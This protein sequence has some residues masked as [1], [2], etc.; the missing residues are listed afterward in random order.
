LEAFVSQ[1][2]E[3]AKDVRILFVTPFYAP[4]W[5]FG[6]PP[7]KI[8]ALARE[9]I[10][11]GHDV[12]IV[13]FQ[14][15][16]PH[17]RSLVTIDSVRVQYLPWVGS[18]RYP[19]PTSWHALRDEVQSAS[20]VHCFGLYNLICPVAAYYTAKFRKPLLVEPMGMFVPRVRRFFLKQIYNLLVTRWLFRKASAVIATSALE[21][22]ELRGSAAE[23][24]IVVRHNGVALE[25]VPAADARESFRPHLGIGRDEQ[26]IGYIGRISRKKGIMNLLR[27]FESIKDSQTKLFI[28]GPIS[29]PDYDEE[30]R[31][32]IARSSR[33]EGIIIQGLLLGKDYV[34]ALSSLDL[35]ILPSENENFGNSAAEAVLAGVP[36]LLTRD[37]G[38]A[39]I[40]DGRVGLAVDQGVN[41]LVEGLK[42]MLEPETRQHWEPFWEQ[43]QS[44]LS[45]DEP[46]QVMEGIYEKIVRGHDLG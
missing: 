40:I 19:F 17:D 5:K 12:R 1:H 15:E 44:E 34:T 7:R 9:L 26:L 8:S 18:A 4:E 36:V 43:V 45:W 30:L 6:G 23:E 21:A 31:E 41:A 20:A 28:A 42:L 33:R 46:I 25:N 22:D 3:L 10:Q 39:P 35:F 37:C 2:S 32:A 14:S 13:T 29:E 16:R 11:R 38:V 24:K 27:A